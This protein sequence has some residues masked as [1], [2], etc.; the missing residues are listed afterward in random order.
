[1][2]EMILGFLM[3]VLSAIGFIVSIIVLIK[4][5]KHGEAFQGI[6][7]IITCTFGPLSGVG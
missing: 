3:P 2:T 6:L 1:M 7:G 4:Q 5:F